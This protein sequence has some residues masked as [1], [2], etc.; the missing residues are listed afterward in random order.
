MPR[1]GRMPFRRRRRR[2][3]GRGTTR[4]LALRALRATDGETNYNNITSAVVPIPPAPA[5]LGVLLNGL[6][7]GTTRDTRL[8]IEAKMVRLDYRLFF[9]RNFEAVGTQVDF[10]K[11]MIVR[12]K[13]PNGAVPVLADILEFPVAAV[14]AVVLLASHRNLI[15]K[16]RYTVL[17]EGT[18]GM[19]ISHQ[20][21]VRT[22]NLRLNFKTEYSGDNQTIVNLVSN[23]IFLFAWSNDDEAAEAPFIAFNCR[24]YYKP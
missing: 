15:Q 6:P 1:R 21:I 13:Q 5:S 20:S 17:K 11:W 14:D 18:F 19:D 4:A 22:G 16:K 23:G 8:G 7:V 3:R 10:I 12:D 9:L 2:G 24:I